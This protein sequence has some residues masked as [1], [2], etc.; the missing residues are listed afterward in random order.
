MPAPPKKQQVSRI[1]IFL[2]SKK[3]SP[4]GNGNI[5]EFT[6]PGGLKNS[7]EFIARKSFKKN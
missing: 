6:R 4:A 3:T 7:S 2:I 1:K 5:T